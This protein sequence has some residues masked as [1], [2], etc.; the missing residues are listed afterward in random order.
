[1]IDLSYLRSIS[2]DNE[3]FITQMV[4]GFLDHAP[5]Y[6]QEMKTACH[7]NEWSS[8]AMSTHKLKPSATYMGIDQLLDVILQIENQVKQ[9]GRSAE[10]LHKL[11]LQVEQLCNDAYPLLQ[12]QL[13]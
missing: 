12:N 3:E 7:Q 8:L 4:Q 9:S 2:D 5:T 13:H 10:Q 11:I 1:M 6:I